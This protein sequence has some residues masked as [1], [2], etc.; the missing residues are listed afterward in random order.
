MIHEFE[1][2]VDDTPCVVRLHSWEPYKPA[3]LSGPPEK[4]YEAEGGYGDWTL[5]VNGERAEWLEKGMS[6]A[7][8]RDIEEHLFMLM[9]G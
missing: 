5:Y 1:T 3:Y 7:A 6:V 9:E 2:E 8:R 4:C